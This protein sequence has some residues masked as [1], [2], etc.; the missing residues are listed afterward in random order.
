MFDL[1]ADPLSAVN[2]LAAFMGALACWGLGGWLVGSAVYWRLHAV[3][4]CGEVIGVRP[5][6]KCYNSVYRYVAPSGETLEATPIEG[7][8]RLRRRGNRTPVPLLGIPHKP[9]EDQ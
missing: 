6:G 2:Q 8:G 9:Q 1:F 7:S 5:K 4:V 3:R